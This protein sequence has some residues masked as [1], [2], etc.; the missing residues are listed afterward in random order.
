[1]KADYILEDLSVVEVLC[2]RFN[3]IEVESA[4]VIDFISD[5]E[6]NNIEEL[7]ERLLSHIGNI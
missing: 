6:I 4:L 1:M 2:Y 3:M 7:A 5:K